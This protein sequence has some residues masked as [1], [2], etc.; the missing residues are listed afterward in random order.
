MVFKKKAP[1]LPA[2]SELLQIINPSGSYNT[3]FLEKIQKTFDVPD[4]E[5]G[6]FI[7]IYLEEDLFI[8][9][10][11]SNSNKL[12][13]KFAPCKCSTPAVPISISLVFWWKWYLIIFAHQRKSYKYLNVTYNPQD[14]Q[15]T[16]QPNSQLILDM[17]MPAH[18]SEN[19]EFLA[20][21]KPQKQF[22]LWFFAIA[23][24]RVFNGS[25]LKSINNAC[26]EISSVFEKKRAS[27]GGKAY[28][29]VYFKDVDQR[30]KLIDI[31][32]DKIY[33]D[34]QKDFERL[35][36]ENGERVGS[37]LRLPPNSY[38]Y[39]EEK[40]SDKDSLIHDLNLQRDNLEEQINYF[41]N[42]FQNLKISIYEEKIKEFEERLE[43]VHYE[44]KGDDSWQNWIYENRWLLGSQYGQVFQKEKVG[45]EGIPDY[46]LLTADGFLD[47]L[48]IKLPTANVLIED[49]SHPGNFQWSSN[50][51]QAISQSINYLDSIDDHHLEIAKKIKDSYDLEINAIKPRAIVLIGCSNDW[52]NIKRERFRSLNSRLH[53]IEVITYTDLLLRGKNIIKLY[54]E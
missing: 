52:K 29:I 43:E 12:H 54:T 17:F 20:Q 5:N 30:W 44:T 7:P 19:S 4:V 35:L 27:K 46:L 24:H 21:D 50:V 8:T 26:Q 3:K 53:R 9:F 10:S 11:I 45:F 31:L 51:S 36:I 33:L 42:L 49:N 23:Y 15:S 14:G 13:K 1:F 18:L 22:N 47:I 25:T 37:Y 16:N 48:E 39:F 40:L 32:R 6:I 28:G 38:K 34:Y 41:N 2:G